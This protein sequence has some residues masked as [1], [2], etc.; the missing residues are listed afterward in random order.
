M[1]Y[2]LLVFLLMG[3]V[4]HAAV[5][6]TFAALPAYNMPTSSNAVSNIRVSAS[7]VVTV[8]VPYFADGFIMSG[9][10]VWV[11]ED[12]NRCGTSFP[13][14]TVSVT[15]WVYSSKDKPLERK[16]K[17]NLQVSTSIIYVYAR[18]QDLV[19]AT[20]QNIPAFEWSCQGTCQ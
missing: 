3:S 11:C 12:P 6:K 18:P 1:R 5:V 17:G 14:S 2:L 8:T 13:A 15:G 4:S 10:P 20:A 16:L 7:T 19:S 9:D